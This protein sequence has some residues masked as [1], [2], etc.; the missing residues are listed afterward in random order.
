M[1]KFW[2]ASARAGRFLN[3]YLDR[4]TG[5]VKILALEPAVDVRISELIGD[6]ARLADRLVIAFV[7]M[8]VRP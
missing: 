3:S 7:R 4:K 6:D 5:S 1:R 8:S 2:H